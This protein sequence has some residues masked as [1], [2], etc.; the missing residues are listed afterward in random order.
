MY[1]QCIWSSSRDIYVVKDVGE[2]RVNINALYPYAR[3][4]CRFNLQ[5]LP[6]KSTT[7]L[8]KFIKKSNSASRI[9]FFC[10]DFL[11]SSS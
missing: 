5:L 8:V 6:N 9:F 4:K 11:N 2:I 7:P 3:K 1:T 10:E